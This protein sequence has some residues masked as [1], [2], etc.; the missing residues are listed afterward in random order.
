MEYIQRKNEKYTEKLRDDLAK[1]CGISAFL[2]EILINR[3]FD[4][5]EKIETFI[6]PNESSFHSPFLF[7]SMIPAVELIKRTIARQGK[8]L[9][10]GDYDC[11]G[12]CATVIMY[13]ALKRAG[14]NVA[15]HLPDRF[16]EGYGLNYNYCDRII[17][18]GFRL[19]ITVDN[20]IAANE[21]VKK[22]KNNNIAVI[23]TDHHEPGEVLP[24]ADYIIDQ[25]CRHETYPFRDI[26]G[27]VVALKV[28][29]AIH[30]KEFRNEFMDLAGLATIADVMP[31][32]NENRYIVSVGMRKLCFNRSIMTLNKLCGNNGIYKA[33]DLS[34]GVISS[35][36][37]CGRIASAALPFKFLFKRDIQISEAEQL[38]QQIFDINAQRK[39]LQRVATQDLFVNNRI[40]NSDSDIL[41]SLQS[42]VNKGVIGLV[43]S[44]VVERTGKAAISLTEEIRNGRMLYTGSGRGNG[45]VN[46]FEALKGFRQYFL[47][48]GGH[49]EAVGVTLYAEN[50]KPFLEYLSHIKYDEKTEKKQEYDLKIETNTLNDKIR[51]ELLLM[52]PTGEGNPVPSF[53]LEEVLFR[54]IMEFS[55]NHF[56]GEVVDKKG[57]L[58]TIGFFMKSPENGRFYSLIID[59]EGKIKKLYNGKSTDDTDERGV[60]DRPLECL[61]LN[62]NKVKQFNDKGIFTVNDLLQYVPRKY[63]DY[64]QPVTIRQII[65]GKLYKE[66]H[67]IVGKIIKAGEGAKMVYAD[68]LDE[69]GTHFRVGWYN[70]PFILKRLFVGRKYI[71]NGLVD[72]FGDREGAL[73]IVYPKYFYG[74]VEKGKK[75]IPVYRKIKGMSDEYL[76]SS[77]EL[78]IN[79]NLKK[80]Y[81][82]DE[83]I[84]K[85]GLNSMHY[86]YR[87]IHFPKN[88]EDIKE[89]T[90]RMLFDH[91]FEYSLNFNYQNKDVIKS[92]DI[93]LNEN[94]SK[95]AFCDLLPYT[96]TDGQNEAIDKIIEET[97]V[98]KRVNALVQG[99]VSCGKTTIAVYAAVLTAL[100]NYQCV[101][102]APTE[103]L[104]G[105]HY[106][107]FQKYLEKFGK[108]VVLVT[109]GLKV[110]EKK[111][112][113]EK[114]KNG[115]ID[116]IVGTH[117]V[118]NLEYYKLGMVIV[119]E[120]HKFGVK[121]R[122]S[123]LK[124]ASK[125]HFIS[126][127][128]TPIPRTLCMALYGNNTEVFEIKAKPM[129]RKEIITKILEND[130]E[131]AE[132][133]YTE[134]QKGH[135]CYVV[136]P[137]I[138]SSES[139]IMKEV[140]SAKETYEGI[141][142]YYKKTKKDVSVGM[143]N[144]KMK[145]E[146]INAE[147]EKFKNNEMNILVSTTIVEVGVNVPNAT[148]MVIKNSERFGLA[149]MHQLRG[150]VGRSSFQ[151]YCILQPANLDD[152]KS[153]AV[154]STN[155]G[156][157]IAKLDA[158]L[159]G[160][161]DMIGTEQAGHNEIIGLILDNNTLFNEINNETIKIIADE[162]RLKSY[163]HILKPIEK[164][165]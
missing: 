63:Y 93:V 133:M 35:I 51:K 59:S 90:R 102:A 150:R 158:E 145:K 91:L 58:K 46:L 6:H 164:Q 100:N 116:V 121:Q 112:I 57:T 40:L 15:C 61:G 48:F 165:P 8:I 44:A 99:A 45:R 87:Q 163:W 25:K 41:V 146:D 88:Q 72:S 29:E 43:A 131:V 120:Q 39:E 103:I 69:E 129:G 119:D 139:Q 81:L 80:D 37:A 7:S 10:Y 36:N 126:M 140:K 130:E 38:A 96:L 161:G 73:T 135:Q 19:V 118:F 98:G 75:L 11:D 125:P 117:S 122:N 92:N 149:S 17:E 94:G 31:L 155:D 153:A 136:C 47:G 128:A 127:S 79:S 152:P 105:Q 123:L 86:S 108:N 82:E 78:A 157:K 113:A 60:D 95:K 85:F 114:I 5:K 20:G 84:H 83:L 134:I 56:R 2:S 76:L 104:A 42:D 111:K 64:T 50:L 156:M 32:I 101:I 34:F 12:V 141:K 66:E 1:K 89:G 27:A 52:E 26:C 74:D 151:S 67:S 9:I 115:E 4:S 24:E 137:S 110:R 3:G 53:L 148:V 77:L 144:G 142:K 30:G 55:S 22:L 14:A 13:H 21:A 154:A 143:I 71:F 124:V 160:Y 54:N 65:A 18:G 28:G 68:C 16:K 49:A 109:S 70:Q 23:V 147:I 97:A 159:R 162:K 107:E 132:F 33:E 138:D 62:L 106:E